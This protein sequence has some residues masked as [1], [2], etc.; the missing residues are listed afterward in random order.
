MPGANA[1]TEGLITF[2]VALAK[3]ADGCVAAIGDA[4]GDVN[5]ILMWLENEQQTHWN[6]QIRHRQDA[7]SRAEEQLRQKKLFKDSSGRT[8][9]AVEEMK[10]VQKAKMQLEEAQQ[11]L[12]NTKRWAKQL[13]KEAILY[14]GAMGRFQ[15]TVSSDI[16]AAVAYL[17]ALIKLIDDYTAV[18]ATGEG[19]QVPPELA[20]FFAGGGAPTM[21]RGKGGA[22]GPGGEARQ[23]YV[24][25][26]VKSPSVSVRDATP[27]LAQPADK[28]AFPTLSDSERQR[29]AQVQVER[30]LP[31]PSDKIV[32]DNS[33][34]QT[35]GAA[36][37]AGLVIERASGVSAG[38]SGWYI[39]PASPGPAGG[40]AT[41]SVAE[42]LG[43]RP[44]LE[45][46]LALPAGYMIVTGNNGIAAVLNERDENVWLPAKES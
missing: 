44:D 16:P 41:I 20:A 6:V 31:A 33:I 12:A 10:M 27:I 3:F 15:T 17:G 36:Q 1:E 4:E 8:A 42:F 25:L 29:L 22:G 32:L 26:R 37:A 14:K 7:L 40:L 43:L 19:A 9:S 23:S 46:I 13:Q 38:D 2:K 30:S 11:K 35:P 21:A 45:P 39:G 24:D 5:R 18:K 34:A 28:S